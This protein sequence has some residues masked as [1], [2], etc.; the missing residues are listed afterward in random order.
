ML[1]AQLRRFLKFAAPVFLII[2]TP[3]ALA[4]EWTWTTSQIDTEGT[5]SSVAVDHDGNVHVSYRVPTHEQLK[6]AFLPIG[7]SH[8]FTMT[9]DGMLSEFLTGIAVDPKGNP[10]ICYTPGVLKIARFDGRRWNTQQVDP[11]GGLIQFYCSVRFGPDG[12]PQLS[13]YVDGTFALRY[14]VFRNGVWVARTVDTDDA[15]GKMNSMA[16]DRFG[17]PQ[18]SY[19]GLTGIRL[20]YARFTGQD[21]NKVSL[22]GRNRSLELTNV[23][24]GMGNSIVVDR[25]NN[26]MISYFDISSLKFAHLVGGKWKFEVVDEFPPV[27]QWG[28]RMFRS[29]TVL[30]RNGNPHIGYQ[31]PLGLKH[32]WWDGHQWRTR[33]I[34][35]P[36][37]T[38]FDGAMAMDDK[39]NL[40]FTYTDPVQ[41]ALMLATGHYNGDQETAKTEASPAAKQP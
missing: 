17:N 39:N 25:D 18:F 30:D 23:D 33:V 4:Q 3:V 29:T 27:P 8:W 41:G 31:C 35:A 1:S 28:W 16:L 10:F 36:A 15:P 12:Q 21:W 20:K 7:S 22:V 40:Y 34:L 9:L 13:W 11:G 6:Y 32:A 26:P 5:D 2:L 38:L 37:G 19:I 24:S 14:G